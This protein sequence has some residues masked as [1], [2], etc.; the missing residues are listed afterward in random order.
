MEKTKRPAQRGR[1]LSFSFISNLG[2]P[3]RRDQN[4]TQVTRNRSVYHGKAR[5]TPQIPQIMKKYLIVQRRYGKFALGVNK[6]ARYAY[7][8]DG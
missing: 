1:S 5:A 4:V 2:N 8:G 6:N 3:W 7:Q